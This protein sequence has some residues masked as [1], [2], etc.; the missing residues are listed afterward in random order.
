MMMMAALRHGKEERRRRRAGDS[1]LMKNK[2][3]KSGLGED[4]KRGTRAGR[5]RT[6]ENTC[7]SRR[8]FRAIRSFLWLSNLRARGKRGNANKEPDNG[9]PLP[10][11]LASF[12]LSDD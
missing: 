8:S 7:P 3:K 6:K 11:F 1:N 4:A 12:S 10:A 5:D 9:A 2:R